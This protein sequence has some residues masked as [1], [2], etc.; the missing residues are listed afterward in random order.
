M[1]TFSQIALVALLVA[2]T[3]ALATAS[4]TLTLGDS[5]YVGFV[6]PSTPASESSEA[7]YI[8]HLITLAIGATD[9]EPGAPGPPGSVYTYSRV[10]ST[11]A[12]PFD[13]IDTS[14]PL[15]EYAW[16]Q[17]N[18]NLPVTPPDAFQYV[19]GRYGGPG[20]HGLVWYLEGGFTGEITIPSKSPTGHGLSHITF[21]NPVD[22]V[23]PEPGTIA[24][25][26]LLAVA[27]YFG[28]KKYQAKA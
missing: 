7:G 3:P 23:V 25:W 26:G 4:L 22:S 6:S 11:H 15:S 20:Q 2:L 12:G 21:F 5:Y 14:L 17:N 28:A 24:V 19:L 8:N 1:K 18:S 16:K 10:S 13:S 27:G 9:T